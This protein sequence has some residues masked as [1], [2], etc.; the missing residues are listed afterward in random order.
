M[1]AHL[2]RTTRARV[3]RAGHGFRNALRKQASPGR[4]IGQSHVVRCDL[5]PAP[6]ET[7]A[8][9]PKRASAETSSEA[10]GRLCELV[11]A[12]AD[13]LRSSSR[14]RSPRVAHDRIAPSMTVWDGVVRRNKGL[15]AVERSLTETV[16]EATEYEHIGRH[17][18]RPTVSGRR[19]D[20]GRVTRGRWRPTG[21]PA[22]RRAPRKRRTR[23]A[24]VP[25]DPQRSAR[26]RPPRGPM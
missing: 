16:L 5:H 1:G 4:H 21:S 25:R 7:P 18:R 22:H 9:E 17:E 24:R 8:T 26:P 23:A 14:L 3:A 19:P 15:A 11:R 12:A 10:P 6:T 2:P 13:G 20:E